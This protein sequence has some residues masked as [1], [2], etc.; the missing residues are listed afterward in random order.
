[1]ADQYSKIAQQPE[2]TVVACYQRKANTALFASE[3]QRKVREII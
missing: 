1:M 2:S 3:S